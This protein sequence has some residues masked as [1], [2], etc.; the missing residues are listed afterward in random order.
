MSLKKM[1]NRTPEN[2]GDEDMKNDEANEEQA[3]L[4][5]ERPSNEQEQLGSIEKFF[6]GPLNKFVYKYK[7]Q[8]VLVSIV[9]FC[10]ASTQAA[11]L[12][13]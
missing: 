12:G 4:D 1:T 13:P 6:D 2:D 7:I 3:R 10:Y 9:W 11:L 8:I 5:D